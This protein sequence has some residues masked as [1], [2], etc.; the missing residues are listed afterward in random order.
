MH[1]ISELDSVVDSLPLLAVRNKDTT[2][3]EVTILHNGGRE[4]IFNRCRVCC[5]FSSKGIC[6]YRNY[7]TLQ[8]F[9][10]IVRS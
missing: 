3:S 5:I 7:P 4:G 9:H 6:F 8:T 1:L 2:A 10:R